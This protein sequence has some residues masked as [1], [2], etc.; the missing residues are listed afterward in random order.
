MNLSEYSKLTAIEMAALVL[1]KDV[2]PVELVQSALAAIA[3]TEPALNAYSEVFAEAALDQAKV[4]ESEARQGSFRGALHGVPFAVKDLLQVKGT[5][6]RRG[7]RLYVNDKASETA[8]L[9]ERL[10][11]AGAIMV[12]KN[13]T[14]DLG[15]KAGS[16]SPLT[17]ATRNPWDVSRTSGGSSSGSAAAV[18]AGVVPI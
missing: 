17:G 4:L 10:Q 2:S 5:N 14:P 7:S 18:A 12:G 6:T 8:P 16:T 11:A 15:W 3:V 1:K 9:V 13:T